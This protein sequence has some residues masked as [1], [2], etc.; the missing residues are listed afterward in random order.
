VEYVVWLPLGRES[1]ESARM[2]VC[3]CV[4]ACVATLSLSMSPSVR[5]S[6]PSCATESRVRKAAAAAAAAVPT[7][8]KSTIRRENVDLANKASQGI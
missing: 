5:L 6:F 2:H 7:N 3:L 1:N 4:R 8:K